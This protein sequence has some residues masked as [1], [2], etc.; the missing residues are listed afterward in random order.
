MTKRR[1]DSSTASRTARMLHRLD[2]DF[3]PGLVAELDARIAAWATTAIQPMRSGGWRAP[4]AARHDRRIGAAS[5][6]L[7]RQI[8]SAG[9][10]LGNLRLDLIKLRS[11][12]IESALGDV[13]TATQEARVLSRNRHRARRGGGIAKTVSIPGKAEQAAGQPRRPRRPRRARARPSSTGMNRSRTPCEWRA[14]SHLAGGWRLAPIAGDDHSRLPKR[15]PMGATPTAQIHISAFL[16][17]LSLI[18]SPSGWPTSSW[19]SG[20]RI[21]IGSRRTAVTRRS[22]SRANGP[23]C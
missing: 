14:A 1:T 18:R 5:R 15:A 17:R 20:S 8:D 4:Q 10:A 3:D 19:S 16:R 22:T 7:A 13:S 6:R 11:S 12:G 21:S 9:L 23:A 2:A